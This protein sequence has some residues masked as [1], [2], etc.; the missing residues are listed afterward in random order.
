MKA[1]IPLFLLLGLAGCM[2]YDEARV[3][4]DLADWTRRTGIALDPSYT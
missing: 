2:T 4:A 3:A 1:L